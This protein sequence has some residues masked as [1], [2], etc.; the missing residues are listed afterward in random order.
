MCLIF[1]FFNQN[2]VSSPPDGK[3][4]KFLN[5]RHHICLF[6]K[7]HWVLEL[8]RASES[9]SLNALTFRSEERGSRRVKGPMQGHTADR[10]QS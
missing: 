3:K 7:F 4:S 2:Q 1:F 6:S 9:N 5:E 10:G 8:E